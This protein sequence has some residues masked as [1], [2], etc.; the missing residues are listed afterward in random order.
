MKKKTRRFPLSLSVRPIDRASAKILGGD[1]KNKLADSNPDAALEDCL[2][3]AYRGIESVNDLR[4]IQGKLK[5]QILDLIADLRRI[6]ST[7][8]AERKTRI[9]RFKSWL[10]SNHPKQSSKGKWSI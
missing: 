4:H 2:N 6:P 8:A 3:W 9:Q 10:G 5:E 1:G 7:D